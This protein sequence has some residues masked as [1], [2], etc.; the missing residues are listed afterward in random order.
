LL[1]PRE[2]AQRAVMARHNRHRSSR[3]MFRVAHIRQHLSSRFAGSDVYDLL[4]LAAFV[5]LAVLVL[6][7]VGDYAISNDEAVQHRYGELI[8][9]YYASGFS[10]ETVFHFENLYLYGGLF[11]V[12][13]ILIERVLPFDTFDIRHMLCAF[14][15]IGGI[16][17]T[18]AVAR[19]V[20]GPRAGLLA[21]LA[22]AICGPWFGTMFN[23]TKDIPFAA[24]MMGATY[25][26][27]RGA[28]D[29]P[30]PRQCDML[31]FGLLLGCALGMRATG[32]LMVGYAGLLVL[33]RLTDL[34]NWGERARFVG[35]S[36]LRALPAVVLA[37]LI[38]I[39]AWPWAAL[40]PLNPLRAIFAFAH[41]D[42]PIETLAF[43][44]IYHMGE[45]PRW[46]VPAY[47]VIKLPLTILA[48]A[49][50]ALFATVWVAK[51]EGIL[52]SLT[53]REISM[54]A[55]IAIFPV[56][57]QVIGQGPA[58]TGMR[59]FMFVVPPLAALAGIGFDALMA[60]LE[61]KSRLLAATALAGVATA[62]MLNA[63][64]LVRLH[65]Y[66]YLF[67]NPLV[68]GL[69]GASRRFDMDYWSNIMPEAVGDLESCLG[70][71]DS[72]ARGPLRRYLVAVCGPRESFEKEAK[73]DPRLIWTEEWDEADFFI[74]S[75]Q[76]DCDRRMPGETIATIERF[77]VPIGVV[78]D[79]RTLARPDVTR[80]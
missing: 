1:A 45:V 65:P 23:H 55:F 27:L 42:Y 54:L 53:Q 48:G 36:I 79:R 21:L 34:A 64:T 28:R 31:M 50:I 51:G 72:H 62:F 6:L 60:K 52:R 7:T 29:L 74:S 67:F 38:M 5:A 32:L 58:F 9:A 49:F 56:L 18:W 19:L 20:A 71:R 80:K 14:A 47:L 16:V 43:G 33:L 66:E 69:E 63:V 12:V 78:K 22:L 44:E 61:T 8:L 13:T 2:A 3:T 30:R 17:A 39:A 75:T 26:L 40:E 15:G 77:G 41:F 37:Y 73:N 4:A 25:F 76:M 10:D 11:D 24:A 68:S 70:L 35:S 57:V 59:H 46:Y